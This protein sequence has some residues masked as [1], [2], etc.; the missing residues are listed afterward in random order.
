MF[1][2]ISA[3]NFFQSHGRPL[4][5]I[6]LLSSL[7]VAARDLSVGFPFFSPPPLQCAWVF[8]FFFFLCIDK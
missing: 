5:E 3:E 6:H 4:G 2:A 8:A 1:L 7:D